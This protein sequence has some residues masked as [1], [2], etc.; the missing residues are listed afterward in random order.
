MGT[1]KFFDEE[2]NPL[3]DEANFLT[4]TFSPDWYDYD[5]TAAI[6]VTPKPNLTYVVTGG[7]GNKYKVAIESYKGKPDGTSTAAAG[8]YFLLRVAPL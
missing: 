1:E 7:G 8:G 3:L 4:T 5:Q 6:P 2:C